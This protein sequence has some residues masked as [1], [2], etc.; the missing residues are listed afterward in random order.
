MKNKDLSKRMVIVSYN[1]YESATLLDEKI[2]TGKNYNIIYPVVYLLRH[3]L[4]L[5]VKSLILQEVDNQKINPSKPEVIYNLNAKKFDISRTHSISVLFDK[6]VEI[7]ESKVTNG[8]QLF[9]Y[10]EN[11][12]KE[13][14]RVINEIDK[15]DHTSDIYR[16]PISK[17]GKKNPIHFADEAEDNLVFG[18]IGPKNKGYFIY[19]KTEEKDFDFIKHIYVK[20]EQTLKIKS[21]LFSVIQKIIDF[22]VY[23]EIFTKTKWLL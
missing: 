20:D 6:F 22:S 11:L 14:S 12:L 19:G 8:Q 10:D 7:Q 23:K 15:I 9:G 1:Y 4:E 13:L 2:L 18:E 17:S 21:T 16:Y 3:S 5:I